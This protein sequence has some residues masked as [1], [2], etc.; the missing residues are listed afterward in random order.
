MRNLKLRKLPLH[1]SKNDLTA[2]GFLSRLEGRGWEQAAR[3]VFPK[4]GASG[5]FGPP[6]NILTKS[7]LTAADFI[8]KQKVEG[9]SKWHVKK[10]RSAFTK[11][12]KFHATFQK[13]HPQ[14][15]LTAADSPPRP[16]GREW[17]QAVR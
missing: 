5:T 10:Q 3:L 8:P 15:Y 16:E 9:E 11:K 6:E 17:E 4:A 7:G 1:F 14:N 13:K 12:H 2:S